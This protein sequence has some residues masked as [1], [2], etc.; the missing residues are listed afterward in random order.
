MVKVINSRTGTI[1][2]AE[3]VVFCQMNL[4]F[5]W[6]VWSSPF[7][8]VIELKFPAKRSWN[9]CRLN[10][11]LANVLVLDFVKWIMIHIIHTDSL[12]FVV[13]SA[14][15]PYWRNTLMARKRGHKAEQRLHN[16]RLWSLYI[17]KSVDGCHLFPLNINIQSLWER[18]P[19]TSNAFAL[20]FS[21]LN[22]RP[23]LTNAEEIKIIIPIEIKPKQP[24]IPKY[25]FWY[26]GSL[27][28]EKIKNK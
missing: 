12:T 27:K 16:L 13:G 17:L 2:L 5:F 14:F 20:I 8:K 19:D 28:R 1:S 11:R 6:W 10:P 9:E 7:M 22:L 23:V 3:P 4:V 24:K 25:S 18:S 26:P 15:E 21:Y